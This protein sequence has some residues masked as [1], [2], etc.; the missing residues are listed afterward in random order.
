M[1]PGQYVVFVLGTERFGLP[2]ES[3]EQIMRD[4]PVTRIPKAPKE[5]LGVFDM[6]GETIPVLD[7][8]AVLGLAKE[9]IT[10]FLVVLINGIK[11]AI[12]TGPVEGIVEIAASQIECNQG[13][14]CGGMGSH[15]GRVNDKLIVLLDPEC[16]I[17]KTVATRTK[18]A[19][20]DLEAAVA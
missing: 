15:T 3:V 13:I 9:E 2:I 17:P 11:A 5:V 10:C 19:V 1:N 14:Q 7:T 4:A 20:A 12:A 18:T 16:L 8:R 6:R